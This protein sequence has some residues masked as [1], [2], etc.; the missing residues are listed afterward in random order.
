MIKYLKAHKSRAGW[1]L[2]G[3]AALI[4]ATVSCETVTRTVVIPPN[5]P[6][7]KYVGSKACAECHEDL[8][9]D[10]KT[11]THARLQTPGPNAINMG[12]ES[13]H[14]PGSLH[15]E[16]AGERRT[17]TNYK[18]GDP[19]VRPSS[20]RQT[21]INPRRSS[22]NCFDCHLDKRGQFELPHHHPVPEGKVSCGDCH[23]PHKGQV[24]KGGGTA[25]QS[26]NDACIKCHPAQRG[27]YVFEH[28]AMREGCT[29]CHDVHG[30]VND[31]MLTVRNQNLCLKCHFQQQQ[32]GRLLIGGW[33]HTLLLKQGTCWTA[34]CHQAVHGSRVNASLRF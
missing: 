15:A 5:I 27:P 9:R 2:A 20:Q 4:L 34:G 10:F 1:L 23:N 13:C 26:Q 33:D 6:G 18:P 25:L 24:T 32:P 19:Q 12:C 22:E 11:A 7:A 29:T 8:C 17:G 28:A 14:G 3:G 30:S 16:S 31:K 21:I